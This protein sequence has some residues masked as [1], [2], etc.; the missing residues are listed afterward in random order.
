M[1]CLD[2]GGAGLSLLLLRPRLLVLRQWPSKEEDVWLGRMDHV[3]DPAA[4]LLYADRSPL[5]L[6]HKPGLGGQPRQ[7]LGQDNVPA[8]GGTKISKTPATK[9]GR[10]WA[11]PGTLGHADTHR[12]SNLSSLYLF[13]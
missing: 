6:R 2:I 10:W 11:A 4:G 12:Y 9:I 13:E 1:A 7:L 8:I 3:V 5:V